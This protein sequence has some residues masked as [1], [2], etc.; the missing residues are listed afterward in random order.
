VFAAL[1][2][3]QLLISNAAGA[4]NLDFNKGELMLITDHLNLQGGSPLALKGMEK[5]GERFVDMSAPY[6]ETLQQKAKKI[7]QMEGI[8]LHSGV[9]AAVVG[10]QLETAAEY[11]YLKIIGADAVGMSTVPEV[12]VAR[13]LSIEVVAFSV[14]TDVC[15]PQNLK[16]IDI[17]DILAMAKKGEHHLIKIVK[18]LVAL[19]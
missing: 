4:V 12:I 11:R 9:Y 13:Q 2:G 1:G 14:L 6:S 7:A 17:P 16:P 18:G 15:D 19:N 10:P 3:I 8:K 5:L